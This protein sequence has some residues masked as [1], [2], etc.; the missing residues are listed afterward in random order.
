MTVTLPD[1]LKEIQGSAFKNCSSLVEITIPAQVNVITYHAFA[2]CS[3]LQRVHFLNQEGWEYNYGTKL[4][5]S[6][7]QKNAKSLKSAGSST[8]ERK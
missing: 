3:S 1:S 6:D 8:W 2:D 4:D 7:A 5:V